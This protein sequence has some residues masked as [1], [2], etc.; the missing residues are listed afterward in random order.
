[1]TA[2]PGISSIQQVVGTR[3]RSPTNPAPRPQVLA[4][5][6]LHEPV[7]VRSAPVDALGVVATQSDGVSPLIDLE[8]D[9][10]HHLDPCRLEAA[11]H[12]YLGSVLDH[13]VHGDPPVGV[14]LPEGAHVLDLLVAPFEAAARMLGNDHFEVGVK[15]GFEAADVTP[16]ERIDKPEDGVHRQSFLSNLCVPKVCVLRCHRT[17]RTTHHGDSSRGDSDTVGDSGVTV[18]DDGGR[19]PRKGGRGSGGSPG[20]SQRAGNES[21]DAMNRDAGLMDPLFSE[22]FVDIDEWRDVPVRHHYL[23]GGFSGTDCRFSIYLPETRH[24]EGRFFHPVSPIPGSEHGATEGAF[25]GYIEFAISSG[26]YLVESNL[27]R[28]RR[29]LRGEDSTIAGYRASAAVATYSRLLA[30]E[31]YG[32]HRP[33]GY[34]FGGSGGAYRAIACFENMPGVWDG[35][36]PFIHGTMMSVPNMFSVQAHAFRVLHDKIPQI[37][38][39]VEPGGSGDMFAGLNEEEREALAEATRMGFPPQAWFDAERIRLQYTTVW[40]GLFDHFVAWDP[41]YFDDFWNLPGYLGEHPTASLIGARLKQETR[42]VETVPAGNAVELG[43]PVPM[44]LRGLHID[45]V[46]VAYRLDDLPDTDLTGAL[47]RFTTGKAAGHHVWVSGRRGEYLATGIGQEEFEHLRGVAIGDAVVL[48]NTA[49]LAFQT[50]HRHQVPGDEYPEWDQFRV[51]GRPIYPQRP[52]LLGP[53]FVRNNGAGTLSGRFAGKMIVVQSLFD[54]IAYPQQA[55]WYRRR[56]QSVLGDRIDDQYRLWFT[57]HAMHQDPA[58]LPRIPV[59]PHRDTRVISYRGILEQA[60]RDVSAWVERGLPPPEST[61]YIVD[62]GQVR[63]RARATDRRGIQPVVDLKANNGSR[64]EVD[65]GETVEFAAF[66]EVPPGAGVIIAAEWDFEGHGDFPVVEPFTNED[67][68]YNSMQ[69]RRQYR[70]SAPGTY[71]PALRVTAHRL[72]QADNSH[73]R[74]MNLGRVRVVVR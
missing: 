70:F 62:D 48:D 43:L 10:G 71:F 60:L 32:A 40:A 74:V 13:A 51:C 26:G 66:V 30:S 5:Q 9:D 42:I 37:V 63:V 20:R 68:A 46:P 29:A 6:A 58:A 17:T 11:F 25:V 19:L 8:D 73:C 2:V 50:Y 4:A 21:A 65:V 23:H 38:D 49:Y 33:Y 47:L 54:E 27:G 56:V 35:A 16:I 15:G 57:E 34:I 31:H 39:A 69:I 61:A 18:A 1:M 7:D 24:Y 59:H 28:F 12:P 72:G 52:E 36:V 55:D 44:A 14:L 45:D 3:R 41:G 64:A 53:R 22:P 67:V